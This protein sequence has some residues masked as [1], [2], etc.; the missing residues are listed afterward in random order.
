MVNPSLVPSAI[1][2]T[3]SISAGASLYA[4]LKPKG[5]LLKWGGPLMGGLLG[6]IL[7]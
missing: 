7:F 4:Y 5:S 3:T 6:L 2:L 1:L